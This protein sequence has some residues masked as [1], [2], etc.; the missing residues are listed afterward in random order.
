MPKRKA[1]P[2]PKFREQFALVTGSRIP[3]S[4]KRLP[5]GLGSMNKIPCRG[6]PPIPWQ[7]CLSPRCPVCLFNKGSGTDISFQE[8]NPTKSRPGGRIR[9]CKPTAKPPQNA[10]EGKEEAAKGDRKVQRREKGPTTDTGVRTGQGRG[11][12]PKTQELL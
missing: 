6:S 10:R 2:P 7:G 5:A 4:I 8:P 9:L 11:G 12:K 1:P 3:S